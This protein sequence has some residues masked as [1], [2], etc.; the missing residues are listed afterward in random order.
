[1]V[2]L[3]CPTNVHADSAFPVLRFIALGNAIGNRDSA[4]KACGGAGH[5]RRDQHPDHQVLGGVVEHT[6]GAT[7]TLTEKPAMP[8]EMWLPLLLTALGFYCF[9][10][11]VLLLRMRLEVLK[12]ERGRMSESR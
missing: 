10:G 6:A 9:F 12:R 3:G 2:G 8:A 7:F 4:A 11:A 1:V 5:C